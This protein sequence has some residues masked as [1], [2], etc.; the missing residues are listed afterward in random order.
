MPI[1]EILAT[2]HRLLAAETSDALA[3]AIWTS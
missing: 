3:K 1:R 2:T